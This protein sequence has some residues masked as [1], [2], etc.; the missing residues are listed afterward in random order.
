MTDSPPAPSPSL[1]GVGGLV[2]GST[3][4]DQFIRGLFG[5]GNVERHK[6]TPPGGGF[7]IM[8][9]DGGG[10]GTDDEQKVNCP[11]CRAIMDGRAEPLPWE[12]VWGSRLPSSPP[13]PLPPETGS[14]SAVATSPRCS[15]R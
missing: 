5:D 9:C 1:D 10:W 11:D 15:P 2:V 14:T 13:S 4:V 12:V 6:L 3:Q 7:T 8:L